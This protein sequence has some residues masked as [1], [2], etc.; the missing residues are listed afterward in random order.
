MDI[1]TATIKDY[2]HDPLNISG[3]DVL[4]FWWRSLIQMIIECCFALNSI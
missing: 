4:M 3:L 2:R 1:E